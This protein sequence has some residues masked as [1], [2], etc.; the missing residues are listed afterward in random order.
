MRARPTVVLGGVPRK[1]YVDVPGSRDYVGVAQQGATEPGWTF[2]V[3]AG[4]GRLPDAIGPA[5]LALSGRRFDALD[6]LETAVEEA[7]Q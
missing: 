1:V 7:A 3:R 6:K 4:H 2:H 5:M